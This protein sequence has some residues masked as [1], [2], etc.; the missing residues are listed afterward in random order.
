MKGSAIMA[1]NIIA[2]VLAPILWGIVG[3]PANQ[4]IMMLFP[5]AG[6]G[7]YSNGYLF[8]ALIA[9]FFYSAIAGAT[10]AWIAEPD[11]KHIGLYAGIAVLTVGAGVQAASWDTLPVWY[12][13]AFLFWLVPLCMIGANIVN[14]GRARRA[15]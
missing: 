8:T 2:I 4:F 5:A 1:K 15:S 13:L 10:A 9:S 12:H 6:Q 11:F 7:L 14:I 3:V